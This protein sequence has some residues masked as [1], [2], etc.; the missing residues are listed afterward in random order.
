MQV[1]D[2]GAQVPQPFLMSPLA[3]SLSQRTSFNMS[4]SLS[5]CYSKRYWSKFQLPLQSASVHGRDAILSLSQIAKHIGLALIILYVLGKNLKYLTSVPSGSTWSYLYK[6]AI[7][8]WRKYS[9]LQRSN[10]YLCKDETELK[11]L[12]HKVCTFLPVTNHKIK[13]S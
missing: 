11:G 8:G 10:I 1:A 4:H 13:A 6:I 2:A 9:D 12:L 5:C 7:S 3:I